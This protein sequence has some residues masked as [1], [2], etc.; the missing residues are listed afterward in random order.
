MA[1]VPF[2]GYMSY[3]R[4]WLVDVSAT[5]RVRSIRP[6]MTPSENKMGK[7]VSIPGIPFGMCLKLRSP[8]GLRLP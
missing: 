2:C 1:M 3:V 5:K 4:A 7:R 6:F 8:A